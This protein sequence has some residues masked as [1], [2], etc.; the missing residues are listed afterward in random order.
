MIAGGYDPM[1]ESENVDFYN[2]ERSEGTTIGF[3]WEPKLESEKADRP[4]SFSALN[5]Q[6]ASTLCYYRF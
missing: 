1:L 3:G 5:Y 4:G 6:V 2:D